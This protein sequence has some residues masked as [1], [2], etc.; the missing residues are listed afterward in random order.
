MFVTQKFIRDLSGIYIVDPIAFITWTHEPG[1]HVWCNVLCWYYRWYLLK[2]LSHFSTWCTTVVSHL[3][4]SLFQYSSES[5]KFRGAI[6]SKK[7][8]KVIPP[9]MATN[10]LW[11]F[12]Q[13]M[14]PL[15]PIVQYQTQ[16]T[17]NCCSVHLIREW[18]PILSMFS[19]ME[20]CSKKCF[21]LV[22][23]V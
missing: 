8:N 1:A 20:N 5:R 22:A 12:L 7:C 11:L 4:T 2:T 18:R 21:Q 6:E 13:D 3:E 23:C 9:H 19:C 10:F 16:K 14:C 17:P 15:A